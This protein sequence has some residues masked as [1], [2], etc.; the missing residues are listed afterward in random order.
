MG[1]GHLRT[2]HAFLFPAPDAQFWQR[3]EQLV[4]R[5]C[6]PMLIL[7]AFES[8]AFFYWS[9]EVMRRTESTQPSSS[10]EAMKLTFFFAF[11]VAVPRINFLH[12]TQISLRSPSPSNHGKYG[13]VH[14]HS[15]L[16]FR[17]RD[18]L[19]GVFSIFEP[20]GDVQGDLPRVFPPLGQFAADLVSSSVFGRH[21]CD[22]R[23]DI[24]AR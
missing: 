20:L 10:V 9:W 21:V 16:S 14:G 11:V 4:F 3:S 19:L 7:W 5:R 1:R 2:G 23:D 24:R 17:S 6:P 18:I 15:I 8:L 13:L 12:C 22:R